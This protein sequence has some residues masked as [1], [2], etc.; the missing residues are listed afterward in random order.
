MTT[1][2]TVRDLSQHIESLLGAEGSREMADALADNLWR[3]NATWTTDNL[4]DL[5]E[6][7]VELDL[8]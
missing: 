3:T 5:A 8:A 4:P 2:T 6:M 7:A 1:F